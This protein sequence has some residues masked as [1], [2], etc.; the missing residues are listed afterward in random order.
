[1]TGFMTGTET[2]RSSVL[3]KD[4]SLDGS[5][6]ARHSDVP[7]QYEDESDFTA[8]DAISLYANGFYDSR[9]PSLDTEFRNTS[10]PEVPPLPAVAFSEKL[11]PTQTSNPPPPQQAHK[12]EPL[13]RTGLPQSVKKAKEPPVPSLKVPDIPDS[14][15]TPTGPQRSPSK[16]FGLFPAQAHEVRSSAS[17]FTG[18]QPTFREPLIPRAFA[19]VDRD[20]YG[21]KKASPYVT[22]Q[23]YDAWNASYTPYLERRKKKWEALMRQYGLTTEKPIRFPPKSDKIKRFVRKGVPPEWRGAAWFWYAGGPARLAKNPG[24]YWELVEQAS[25]GSGSLSDTYREHIE[26]DLNRTFPDNV[27]FRPDTDPNAARQGSPTEPGTTG[28][29]ETPIL[30]ALRRL[31]QAF[32]INNPHIGYCQ[33]LNFLAGLLLLFLDED[34]EKAF[35]LLDVVTNVHLPG[36]HGRVLEANVDIGVLM[37]CIKDCM[38][39]TWACI[40]DKDGGGADLAGFS[41]ARLP[42]VSLATTAWFMSCFVGCFPIES[43]LRVWDSL[44]YEGSKTLFRIALTIFK[45]GEPEIKAMSERDHMEVFQLVQNLP[46]KM[47]D[48]NALMEA[49]FKRRNGFGHLSQETID[50]RRTERRAALKMGPSTAAGAQLQGGEEEAT[51]SRNMR[52]TASKRVKRALSRR[53]PG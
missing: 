45:V 43:V 8:E 51:R 4:T 15:T 20:R 23:Q 9:P 49:C 28:E 27:R 46:R 13:K 53:R 10:E 21:F 12:D 33:S 22:S 2:E 32:A 44:F 25:N 16:K 6:S 18:H 30:R 1:M 40:D 19:H 3:T 29:E 7:V 5:P 41:V 38:P 52:R 50:S 35:I 14:P 17:I 26:G 36:T 24:L 48:C 31:L 39:N 37:S 42:T 11:E 34:E 47:L